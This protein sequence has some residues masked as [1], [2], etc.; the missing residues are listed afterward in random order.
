MSLAQTPVGFEPSSRSFSP[1]NRRFE[2][3]GLPAAEHAFLSGYCFKTEV[4]KQP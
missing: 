2:T 4:L 1:A 3:F